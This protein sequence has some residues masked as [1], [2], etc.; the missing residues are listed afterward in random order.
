MCLATIERLDPRT[1]WNG[2]AT[3]FTP[4]LRDNISV[5]SEAVG[6]D[7]E[8][9]ESEGAIGEFRSVFRPRIAELSLDGGEA[10]A[11]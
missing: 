11:T 3:E 1:V 5:L 10:R 2:E 9:I 8:V 6:M 4:W 7:L